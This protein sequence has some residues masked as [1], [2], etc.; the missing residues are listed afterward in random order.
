MQ[1]IHQSLAQMGRRIESLETI[2]FDQV[3]STDYHDQRHRFN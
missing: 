2:P 3:S 1:V